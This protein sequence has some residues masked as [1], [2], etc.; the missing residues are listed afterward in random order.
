MNRL[1]LGFLPSFTAFF[2]RNGFYEKSLEHR[3]RW[4]WLKNQ[5][6]RLHH[7]RVKLRIIYDLQSDITEYSWCFL[8]V[9]LWVSYLGQTYE[10]YKFNYIHSKFYSLYF[11]NGLIIKQKIALQNK[12]SIF[13]AASCF[14]FDAAHY[15]SS[16]TF[17]LM[18]AAKFSIPILIT[19]NCNNNNN[20]QIKLNIHIHKGNQ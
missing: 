12:I 18:C 3:S 19:V 10:K 8:F 7:N 20:S 9:L 5:K 4:R 15:L 17:F 11:K 13:I 2:L 1:E 16:V 6:K 14:I